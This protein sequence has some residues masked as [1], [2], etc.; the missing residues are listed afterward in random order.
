MKI[1]FSSRLYHAKPIEHHTGLSLLPAKSIECAKQHQHLPSG[2]ADISGL[3]SIQWET[4]TEIKT[5]FFIIR[6]HPAEQPPTPKT[7]HI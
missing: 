1:H 6:I 3:L 5:S 7:L 2:L 4:Q